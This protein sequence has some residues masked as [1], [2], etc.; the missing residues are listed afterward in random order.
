[1]KRFTSFFWVYVKNDTDASGEGEELRRHPANE[2][3]TASIPFLH[4]E[5]T[6]LT[7]Y[8]W[9]SIHGHPDLTNTPAGNPC[10]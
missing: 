5:H 9:L 3:Y 4:S 1:M 10:K 8:F 7:P 2:G 6:Q